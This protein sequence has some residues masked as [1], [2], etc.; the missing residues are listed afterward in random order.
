MQIVT[1]MTDLECMATFVGFV[2]ACVG[3]GGTLLVLIMQL[4]EKRNDTRR[5]T[6]RWKG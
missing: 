3:V 5:N 6:R 2:L 1:T 4:I